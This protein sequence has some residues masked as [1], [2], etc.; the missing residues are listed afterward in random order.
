MIFE[1]FSINQVKIKEIEW[2]KEMKEKTNENSGHQ[3]SSD[4]VLLLR[5]IFQTIVETTLKS[6]WAYGISLNEEELIP[7]FAMDI[8]SGWRKI[9]LS[10]V[11]R[12]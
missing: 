6:P 1:P 4:M 2:T 8:E 3:W 9:P 11:L 7:S 5:L 12:N 10:F